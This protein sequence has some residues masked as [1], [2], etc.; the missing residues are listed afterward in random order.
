LLVEIYGP[1]LLVLLE[2]AAHGLPHINNSLIITLHR[3][4]K[5]IIMTGALDPA[6][7][8]TIVLDPGSIGGV[9]GGCCVE[10]RGQPKF[11]THG[12]EER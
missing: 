7:H 3:Q 6:L 1:R 12:F 9:G 11:P 5:D 4:I 8:G 10:V 2:Q